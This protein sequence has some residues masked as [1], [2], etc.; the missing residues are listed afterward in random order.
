MTRRSS[1]RLEID[2]AAKRGELGIPQDAVILLSIGELNENKNHRTVIE[3][4][5]GMDV[6]YLIAGDGDQEDA[7]KALAVD[8]GMK[9]RVR[10]LGYRKDIAEL[11]AVTDV[12]VLP[13]YREGLSVSLMEA[14]ASGRPLVASRIRGNMD[15]CDENGG[16]LFDPHSADDCRNAIQTV[17]RSDRAAL[18][19]YNR[20]KA[21]NFTTG[22]V[23]QKLDEVYGVYV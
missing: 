22:I 18:S 15:L 2:P 7:L 14:M 12:F 17:L 10:F 9:D 3:A 5:V 16:A 1:T 11:L 6:Y 19:A 20:E 4:I 21:Y 8:L 23:Q 13:S